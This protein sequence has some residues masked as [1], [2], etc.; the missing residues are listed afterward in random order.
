MY[1][2]ADKHNRNLELLFHPGQ[3]SQ[4]EYSEEL[5]LDYFKN[6]NSS[7]NRHVEKDTVLRIKEIVR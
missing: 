5:N 3:V 2:Y 1:N 6:A 4:D 7:S